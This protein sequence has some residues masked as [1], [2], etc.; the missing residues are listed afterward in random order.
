VNHDRENVDRI[1]ELLDLLASLGLREKIQSIVFSPISPAPKDREGMVP[2]T[3]LPC[4]ITSLESA[5]QLMDLKRMASE[6]GFPVALGVV[7]R[8]CEMVAKRSSFV[9]DPHGD[10]YRCGG[11]AGRKGFGFGAIRGQES[12]PFLGLELWRR[13]A[14]CA[15]APLCTDGCLFGAYVR[16]GDPLR[17]N[18]G[19]DAMAYQVRESLKLAYRAKARKASP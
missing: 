11:F 16:Y 12:D 17:L 13:C 19:L 10:L 5:R 3:E 15:Y 7:A 8:L 14:H 2:A 4:A 1:P 18:C 9:I 6:M